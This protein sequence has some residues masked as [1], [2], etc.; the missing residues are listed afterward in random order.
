MS[1]LA[2]NQLENKNEI[3]KTQ[4]NLQAVISQL[5]VPNEFRTPIERLIKR[6]IGSFAESDLELGRTDVVKMN[7]DTGSNKPIK[8]PAY[9]CPLQNRPKVEE[10][11][12]KMLEA[13]V[14]E[15]I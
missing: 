14:I 9:R 12:S 15:R 7:I 8:V 11:V 6:N 3:S 2:Y 10:A 13:G 4:T 1:L 5:K